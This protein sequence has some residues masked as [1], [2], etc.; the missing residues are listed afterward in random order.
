MPHL[1]RL[2]QMSEALYAWRVLPKRWKGN[3]FGKH[4]PPELYPWANLKWR[5]WEIQDLQS[6]AIDLGNLKPCGLIFGSESS[7]KAGIDCPSMDVCSGPRR[8]M[9][10]MLSIWV[11]EKQ[12]FSL[13]RILS[14]WMSCMYDF[15]V[16]S[17][18]LVKVRLYTQC[19]LDSCCMYTKNW[20]C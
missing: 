3:V 2:E 16:Y 11:N 17:V 15:N 10:V 6:W 20:Y 4:L 14:G 18:Y 19:I 9:P 13:L 5:F 12:R 7:P 8:R 1:V